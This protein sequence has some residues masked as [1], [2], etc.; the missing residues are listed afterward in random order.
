M[1][2][3]K[4]RTLG[5][6]CLAL[7]LGG[8]ARAGDSPQDWLQRME[9]AL[10]GRNYQGVFVHE[11]GG[12]TETLRIVHRASGGEIGERIVSLDGS[13]REFIRR[14]AE[15]ICYLPD[16]RTVLVE[17]TQ[18]DG[19]LLGELR[20]LDL[21]A[22]GQYQLNEV[23]RTRVSGRIAR[24]ISVEPQDAYRYGYRL[25]IDEASAMPL[26][27]QL[28]THR[29]QV[30][31]QIVFTELALPARIA[32]A[33]LETQLDTRAYRWMRHESLVAAQTAGT[34]AGTA[35]QARELPPGFRMTAQSRQLLPGSSRPVTHLVYSDGLASVSVFVEDAA[36]QSSNQS[37]PAATVA[38][39]PAAANDADLKRVGS[40]SA[41]STVV[42]GHRV[43]AIGEVPPDTVRAIANSMLASPGRA[44]SS[45]GAPAPAA[46]GIG[47]GRR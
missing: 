13:G 10:A 17:S 14:G 39:D 35:W 40:S 20:R 33:A 23:A 43:T 36:R 25:W 3:V 26:K 15:L 44:P 21:A 41:F 46:S 8:S 6:M 31:E 22:S 45:V 2:S 42:Q 16:Q 27:T 19:M 47:S 9:T 32:D 4:A 28:R 18:D 1:P 37:T 11:H 34:A 7:A 38:S 12:Q 5:G 29:G 24:V 30:V